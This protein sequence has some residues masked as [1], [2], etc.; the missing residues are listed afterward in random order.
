VLWGTYLSHSMQ[1][2]HNAA[3]KVARQ[4]V[5]LAAHHEHWGFSALGNRFAGQTLNFMGAF[6]DARLHL[7]RALDLCAANRETVAAYRKYGTKTAA[8]Q[9]EDLNWQESFGATMSS[10]PGWSAY[11][12][13][14]RH[15]P[16]A[17]AVCGNSAR[18]DLGGGR[19]V[20]A[21]P[22]ALHIEFFAY[23]PQ[24]TLGRPAK[25]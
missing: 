22:T 12:K 4:L 16:K 24:Q 20:M 25:R 6:V 7:E 1:A 5:A 19:S 13:F 11:G 21:V 3:L 15:T 9:R 10:A 14:R 18:T 8:Q 17:G 2:E 23:D